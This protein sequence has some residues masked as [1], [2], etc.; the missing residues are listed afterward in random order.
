MTAICIFRKFRVSFSHVSFCFA[1]VSI[2]LSLQTCP[3]DVTLA[4]SGSK[5]SVDRGIVSDI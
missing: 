4:F 2:G 1:I 3:G 5:L